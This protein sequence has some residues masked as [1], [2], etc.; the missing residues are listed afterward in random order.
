[1][2]NI[3]VTLY[4]FPRTHILLTLF[5]PQKNP[6]GLIRQVDCNQKLDQTWSPILLIPGLFPKLVRATLPLVPLILKV[7]TER[8]FN[9]LLLCVPIG[10]TYNDLSSNYGFPCQ[11]LAPGSRHL[12]LLV[13]GLHLQNWIY[14]TDIPG[15]AEPVI[16]LFIHLTDI[17]WAEWIPL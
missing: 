6:V 8:Q 3:P 5:G 4:T 7:K 1:M 17:F 2:L 12:P 11:K 13:L 16:P 10:S 9:T 15:R 14:I